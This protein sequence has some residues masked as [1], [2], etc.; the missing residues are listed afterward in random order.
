MSKILTPAQAKAVYDAM[1]AL[2]NVNAKVKASFGNVADTG[3]N[4]FEDEL[5]TIT[6]VEVAQ[7]NV[8]R[9]EHYMNQHRFAAAYDVN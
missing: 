3:V 7:Y 6:V 5:D 1:S 8:V 4:V 9:A 2:N